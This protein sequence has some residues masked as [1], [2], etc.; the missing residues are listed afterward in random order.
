MQSMFRYCINLQ[1]INM[2]NSI[3]Y[4]N[5]YYNYIFEYIPENIVYCV[6]QDKAP[7]INRILKNKKCS[8]E[9]CLDN[10]KEKQKKM[11]YQNNEY[12]CEISIENT[13]YIDYIFNTTYIN[14]ITDNIDFNFS[15]DIN[16]IT[17]STSDIIFISD[18]IDYADCI[19]T[20]NYIDYNLT[21]NNISN[22]IYDYI[23]GSS[24]NIKNL[25]VNHYINKN[26]N[27][28]I[29]IFNTWYCTNLLLLYDY[30]E[31][32]TNLLSDK[33]NNNLK[34]KNNY[35]FIYINM[36][37][38]NY[39]EIYDMSKKSKININLICP[40]CFEG[41]NL[42]L[43]NNFTYELYFELGKVITY[44]IIENNIDPFN[45]KNSIFNNICKNFTIEEID[46][47]IKERRQI[48]FLGYKEK[49]IICNDIY[50][51]IK[52]YYLS[53]FTGVCN[54]KISNNFNYL[55]S[56]DYNETNKMTFEEYKIFI[57][58]KSTI[59][60]FLIFKCGKEAFKL[61]NIKINVGFYISI[62]FMV[63][64]LILYGFNIYFYFNPKY[65]IKSNPPPKIQKFEIKDDLEENEYSKEKK[66]TEEKINSDKEK[67]E[68]QN[69]ENNEGN[70]I[71]KNLISIINTNTDDNLNNR[72]D[73][74]INE[75]NANIN[76]NREN[77]I[78]KI[79]KNN[80]LSFKKEDKETNNE[81][82]INIKHRRSIKNLPP[83]QKNI[84]SSEED[85]V[86][87]KSK[88]RNQ[89]NIIPII[90]TSKSFMDYYW[91]FLSL[92]QPIINLL[93]PIKYLNVETSYIPIIVKLMKIIFILT[94]NIFFNLFHLE[95]KYFRK[96]YKYFNDRFNI[97]YNFLN[98]NISLNERF[99]YGFTNAIIS[100]LIS[101]IICFIIQTILNYFFFNIRKK[102][103]QI[104]NSKI[105]SISKSKNSISNTN[106]KN[107]DIDNIIILLEKENKKY[108]I[109]FC[110]ALILMILIFYSLITF[111][112]VYRGGI[113]DLVAGVFWT[114]IF[115]E[116]IPFIYC[117]I[118]GFIKYRNIKNN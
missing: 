12:I 116:I 95:Q 20:I 113:T 114:F 64:Q 76:N 50:C 40:D 8:T 10:W 85:F 16:L 44:K 30:F 94:L 82:L 101:F 90:K 45:E 24:N 109:F 118:L 25:N 9:Y 61:N 18:E 74:N 96:K 71:S 65:N 14:E 92:E 55:I 110:C 13:T 60:S 46:I 103:N 102:I 21:M 87:N 93:E 80:I 98:K 49:Q 19:V 89:E 77:S 51:N 72:K 117:F 115:L 97:R 57:N 73:I 79:N 6:N 53:N 41:N 112:E 54:C 17:N 63:I 48:I 31:I 70:I 84:I 32:N 4:N 66:S 22:Y 52:K 78:L 15:S 42:I 104:N 106:K 59:N 39:I 67:D 34:N 88:E 62:A 1:Y 36:N 47:P 26:L 100:G 3:E 23:N 29:T 91:E 27:F 35:I 86:K 38:K 83:I 108:L 33:L 2:K 37:N 69:T 28:T 111:N 99:K 5:L 68:N 7:N 43:K 56:N 58:S 105:E 81:K 75:I 107:E 11:I